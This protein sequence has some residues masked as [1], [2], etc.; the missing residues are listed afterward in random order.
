MRT[1]IH[2]SIYMYIYHVAVNVHTYM[3]PN[4]HK[5]LAIISIV[6]QQKGKERTNSAFQDQVLLLRHIMQLYDA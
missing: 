3:A 4:A 1:H 2:I 5:L 6:T